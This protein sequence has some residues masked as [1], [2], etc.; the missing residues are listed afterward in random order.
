[1]VSVIAQA[2]YYI[3][4]R[5]IAGN[6]SAVTMMKWMFLLGFVFISPFC[7]PELPDQRIFS[8]EVTLLPL[9]QLG[10]LLIFGCVLAV[11][12]LPVALKRIK[13]TTASMYAN[14]QPLVT[15]LAAIII[16]Q[17]I[18]TWDKPLALFLVV[19]GVIIVTQSKSGEVKI[20]QPG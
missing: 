1:M 11:F 10:F 9:L 20:K 16:G 13:A 7:A 8:P 15:S 18:L 14:I 6:Y 2:V 17:D 3:I 5:K 12:L 19:T 4:I